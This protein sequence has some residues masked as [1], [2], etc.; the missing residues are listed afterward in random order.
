MVDFVD[1][2]ELVRRA[3]ALYAGRLRAEL[4]P[5]HLHE[6]AA[7]EPDSERYFLGKTLTEAVH[8]ARLVFPDRL[9]HVVRVGH[10]AAIH[11]GQMSW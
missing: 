2:D 11:M 4:E 5:Q 9:T 7:I 6:F 10:A 3:E 1:T 8:N